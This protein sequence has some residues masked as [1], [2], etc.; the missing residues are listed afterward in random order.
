MV[1]VLVPISG[2]TIA[3]V[4]PPS[5]WTATWNQ[6]TGRVFFSGSTIGNGNG[7]QAAPSAL[8]TI[9][10]NV[11]RQAADATRGWSVLLSNDGGSSFSSA[12]ASATGTLTSAIKVLKVVSVTVTAPAG[13][14]DGDVTEG[15]SVSV[16]EVVQNAGSGALSVT[17]SL[18]SADISPNP[19]TPPAAQTIA[20][21]SQAT[22]TFNNVTFGSKP[23]N[24]HKA[25]LAGGATAPGANALGASSQQI[26]IMGQAVFSYVANSLQPRDVV[27]GSA[28]AFQLS[29][30]K[31]GDVAV[32]TLAATLNIGPTN[33][34]SANLASVNPA[35][36]AGGNATYALTFASTTVPLSIPDGNY[37]PT[38][39]ITGSDQNGFG[40]NTQPGVL[41]QVNLDRLAPVV[42]PTI[43]PPASRVAG[44]APAATNGKSNT[45][46]GSISDGGTACS[47]C[48]VSGA[49]I[50]EL[51][52][53]GG[54]VK[55][56][57][58]TVT[59]SGGTISGT[60]TTTF[61]PSTTAMQL[62]VTATDSAGN[63][64]QGI[65]TPPTPVDTIAPAV[66]SARTGGGTSDASRIDVFLTERVATAA[67]LPSDWNVLNHTVT[68]AVAAAPDTTTG[69]DHVVLTVANPTL[70]GDETPTVQYSP[71][72]A[73]RASDR[74]AIALPNKGVTA[75]D[76]IIPALPT[77]TD[78][79]GHG[80]QTD[81]YYTNATQP[82]FTIGSVSDGQTVRVYRDSNG[83]GAIDAGE[84]QLGQAT[85]TG[86]TATVTSSS[87]GTIDQTFQFLVRTTD[88]ANNVGP[89][90]ADQLH[91]DF[92]VPT[93]LSAT[94]SGN[95]ITVAF[96]EPLAYGREA[97]ADWYA[98]GATEGAA[99]NFGIGSV[100]GSG[101][102]R[103]LT[104]QDANFSATTSTLSSVAYDFQGTVV[105][106]YT[107]AAG[108]VLSNFTKS[109]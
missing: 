54:T 9:N 41:N 21:A 99:Y 59:N 46:G 52:A 14:A 28:Y 10:A 82:V 109:V 30:S 65:S 85:A 62:Y 60:F 92:T 83:N 104:I 11:L 78:V 26:T 88:T 15:Q 66:S 17:P 87:L 75:A 80:R 31:T 108:N 93:A 8:F 61:D 106:R 47:G 34:F 98:S 96:S 38:L 55:D 90:A 50:R 70:A 1:Q 91:L 27:P 19:A 103:A 22:Y 76:G 68:N 48:A 49:F 32:P 51:N 39:T 5:G 37:T 18:S 67:M 42:T 94:A 101:P 79:S 43:T 45:L 3:D 13:A 58:V 33:Q 35:S 16:Q 63:P 72:D 56:D 97:A 74:V 4:V 81:G 20:S 73:T 86:T 64:T 40:I 105:Q 44:A 53:S 69:F 102:S 36:V 89:T 57:P 77:I 2:F 29:V 24:G 23:A 12:T 25:V 84:P 100:S 6:A 107:D 7:I 95:T 71:S